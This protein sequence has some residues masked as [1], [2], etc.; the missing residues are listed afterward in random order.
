MSRQQMAVLTARYTRSRGIAKAYIRYIQ[1]RKGKD[2]QKAKRELYG[3]DGVMEGLQAYQ[4]IDEA[5][6]EQGTTYFRIVISPDPTKEDT[7]RDLHLQELTRQTML[8][9]EERLQKEV[10]YAAAEH[11]DHAPHRHIHVLA[12]VRGRVNTQD[13]Q[14]LR[15]TATQT[16][17]GQRQERD[18]QRQAQQQKGAGL[19]R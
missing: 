5:E 3:H 9:L 16:A 11:N 8:T 17:L 15:D 1:H 7:E 2:G 4:M 19:Q 18:L 13:L 14:A 12:L 10:P 6:N